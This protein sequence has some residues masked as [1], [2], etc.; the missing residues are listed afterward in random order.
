MEDL[1]WLGGNLGDTD[2]GLVLT[3]VMSLAIHYSPHE[4][5]NKDNL[6]LGT[7]V[8]VTRLPGLSLQSDLL[9]LLSSVLSDVFVGPL[10]DDLSL[11]LLLLNGT[12]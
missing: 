8:K 5:D 7:N 11:L 9:S 10:E 4:P 3:R 2:R 1:L 6:G 12:R